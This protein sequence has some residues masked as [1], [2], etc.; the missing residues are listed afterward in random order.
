M[1]GT[2]SSKTPRK[3]ANLLRSVVTID[4]KGQMVI[5]KEVRDLVNIKPGDKIAQFASGTTKGI[6]KVT[7]VKVTDLVS[8]NIIG[9]IL[10]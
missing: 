8:Q 1:A 6:K 9:Q 5:S 10:R 3:N 2:K 7:L 4:E